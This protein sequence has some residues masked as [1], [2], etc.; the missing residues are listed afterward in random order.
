MS[1]SVH[2]YQPGELIRAS[3][4]NEMDEQIAQNESDIG[5]RVP[6]TR[7]VNGHALSADVTVT[8]SDVGLGNVDN[9]ADMNKPVSTAQQTALDAKVPNTRKVNGHALSADVTLSKSDVGLGNVDN[10]ADMDKPVS[11]A[12]QTAL[13]GKVDKVT[14]KGLSANDFT[15][16]MKNK[17][18]GIEAGANK[19]TVDDDL[20]GTSDNPVKNRTIKAKFDSVDASV[21]SLNQAIGNIDIELE[22]KTEFG[23]TVSGSSVSFAAEKALPLAELIVKVIPAQE[24]SG[25]PSPTNIRNFTARSS[26]NANVN[27]TTYSFSFQRY[28]DVYFATIDFA[29]GKLTVQPCTKTKLTNS[30]WQTW[31]PSGASYTYFCKNFSQAKTY[32]TFFMSNMFT[33]T[34]S[35]SNAPDY[36]V[37]IAPARYYAVNF[38]MTNE[39]A[40]SDF[41]SLITNNDVYICVASGA[42]VEYEIPAEIIKTI[43]GNNTVS[44]DSGDV[45]VKYLSDLKQYVDGKITEANTRIDTNDADILSLKSN[46]DFLFE[47]PYLYNG[48]IDHTDTGTSGNYTRVYLKTFH[49][50]DFDLPMGIDLRFDSME[51]PY[52]ENT[53]LQMFYWDGSNLH[54]IG[55]V[56][57]T[58]NTIR[59]YTIPSSAVEFYICAVFNYGAATTAGARTIIK[60]ATAFIEGLDYVYGSNDFKIDF[61][62]VANYTPDYWV[63]HITDKCNSIYGITQN[64]SDGDS[65]VFLTDYHSNRNEAVSPA[66]I[67]NIIRRTG[68]RFVVFG[69]DCFDSKSSKNGANLEILKV[70]RQLQPSAL[71]GRK[72]Y[73]VIGNHEYNNPGG[74]SSQEANE[75]SL[76]AVYNQLYRPAEADFEATNKLCYVVDNKVQKIRYF[77]V[78]ANKIGTIPVDSSDWVVEQ[79]N[80]T[81]EEYRIVVI[82]HVALYSDGTVYTS[83]FDIITALE[84]AKTNGHDVAGIISGHV[85]ADVN[86]TTESGIPIIATTCDAI[87]AGSTTR[88]KGTISEQAFDVVNID[89][90]NRKIHMTRIGYGSDREFDF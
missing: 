80:N 89:F 58:P 38:K 60:G 28:G 76:D 49:A 82:S 16:T 62:N 57:R 78:G 13:G 84:N 65:F 31:K 7:K 77:F 81:P 72:F 9:T 22:K 46:N 45:T 56:L 11:T 34:D 52:S 5:D 63:N 68:T 12:T 25:T 8:K 73:P 61:R 48:A 37:Y 74:S 75:L 36:S 50:E 71:Y 88:T 64:Y 15:D 90:E 83:L 44:S 30:G 6:N 53:G 35:Q 67:N 23:E 33:L 85:H 41:Q 4:L 47:K 27:G 24:G 21:T 70:T 18:D 86:T 59:S 43:V 26:A 87:P 79:I 39:S 2:E 42:P 55:N 20:S 29:R 14:G 69:G 54:G 66:L 10:T 17:L 19:T 51:T 3:D 1:Y 40:L 32:P